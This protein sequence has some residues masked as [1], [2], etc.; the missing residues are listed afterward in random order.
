MRESI[1]V[2][3]A[4]GFI[5]RRL[6]SALAA[7]GRNVIAATRRPLDDVPHNVEVHAR[8]FRAADD[9]LPLLE[10]SFAVFDLACT[11]TPGSTARTPGSE[12]V[13]NLGTVVGL[14][15]A[16]QSMAD[17]RAIHVSSGGSLYGAA[18]DGADED[19]P[20]APRS[21]HGAA[22]AAAEHFW[23][24]W[25]R[26]Y[27]GCATI[28]RPSNIFGPGQHERTGFAVIPTAMVK[29]MRRETLTVWGDGSAVRD[30]LYID[31]FVSLCLNVLAAPAETGARVFN[32][33]SGIGTSLNEL[34]ALIEEVSGQ[35]LQRTCL[36]GRFVDADRTVLDSTRAKQVFGWAPQ[37]GLREGL[38][39]TWQWL[40][41]IQH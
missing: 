35:P 24:A 16:L 19:A 20:I 11:S 6:V 2:T 5:G 13:S 29:M 37:V 15:E 39:R 18:A 21:Y 41:S 4:G 32:A 23:G 3:G 1:L 9:F 27:G 31:D 17:V 34:L 30:Y 38:T 26:Q 36:A 28:L 7:Q 8:E 40:K 10:R 22:K 25:C 12:V 33:S 14:I